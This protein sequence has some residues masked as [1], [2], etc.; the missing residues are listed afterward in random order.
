MLNNK[1]ID[2]Y[3]KDFWK[4]A[5]TTKGTHQIEDIFF[6][7]AK[8]ANI[9]FAEFEIVW[10]KVNADAY[11]AFGMKEAYNKQQLLQDLIQNYNK[12]LFGIGK[13]ED[14]SAPPIIEEEQLPE[15]PIEEDKPEMS[16]DEDELRSDVGES[17]PETS[18]GADEGIGRRPKM[19]TSPAEAGEENLVGSLKVNFD[20]R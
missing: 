10:G 18:P 12:Y 6:E 19:V 4:F 8:E 13:E 1:I 14:I 15:E 2:A 16:M 5:S 20:E 11:Q 9:T 7:W 17:I 3:A